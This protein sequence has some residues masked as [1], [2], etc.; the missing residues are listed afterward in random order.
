MAT[1][2]SGNLQQDVRNY[3]AEEVL[4]IA[5]KILVMHQFGQKF[6]LPRGHGTAMT[7]T[8]YNRLPLPFGP[9]AEGVPSPSQALTIQQVNGVAQQWG[10][11]V[12]L[13]DVGELTI[14]HNPF[15]QA[16]R[17]V[18]LQVAETFDRNDFLALMGG[19]QVNYVS[20]RGSRAALQSGDVLDPFTIQRTY[21][22]LADI[23]A[24]RF[25]AEPASQELIRRDVREGQPRAGANPRGTPHYVAVSRIF[26][27]QDLR[28]NGAVTNAWAFSDINKLYNAEMG[29]WNGIRFCE[30]NMVP[31]FTG[32]AAV[33]ATAGTS[34]NLP[35][36]TYSVQVSGVDN[37]NQYEQRIYQVQTGL[38]VTGPTGSISLTTPNV[39]GYTFNVYTDTNASPQHLGLSTS[40]PTTGAT[41]GQ[42]VQLPPNTAVVIT[43]TGMNLTPPAAPG[44]G[45]TV[46]PVFVFGEDSFGIVELQ[47]V[48][49][50]YLNS[51][52]KF[53]PQNQLRVVA[54][55]A[56]NGA[57]ILN[58]Q[59]MARIECASAF[60][61]TFG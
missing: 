59:F 37:Q 56:M 7:F 41:S 60:S 31:S 61:P 11:Q 49:Y 24:P 44:N 34:G 20:T 51:A 19:T 10:G 3:L 26:P 28:A 55:K 32:F 40:G 14:F 15:Q 13:T 25:N 2:Y 29:E 22:A 38:S 16:K 5:Q 35:T 17:L 54:W 12:V 1:T 6:R 8:R 53:D 50:S 47:D 4:P 36:G 39:A 33:T 46:Y 45:V 43:G 42:A 18:A 52:E 57:M 27:I 9:I 23:A 30:S 48:E 58:A 21:A